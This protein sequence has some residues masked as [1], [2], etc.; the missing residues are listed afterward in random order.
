M[1]VELL[2]FLQS[3]GAISTIESSGDGGSTEPTSSDNPGDDGNPSSTDE[4]EDDEPLGEP[5]KKA[6]IA[7]REARK[8]ADD[9]RK[10]A[11]KDLSAAQ[12]RIKEL[13]DASN[14]DQKLRDDLAVVT[15]ERDKLK[16]EKESSELRAEVLSEKKVPQNGHALVRGATREELE[17][18]ADAVLDLLKSA[19]H[20]PAPRERSGQ[21][22]A[23]VAAGREMFANDK[24]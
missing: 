19:H 10:Q 7:E 12:A 4:I 14:G 8:E 23:S 5:G 21:K 2:K 20:I 18:S 1:P 3:I 24:K 11:E 6:L 15:K 17:A 9:A 22:P 16:A 13:E